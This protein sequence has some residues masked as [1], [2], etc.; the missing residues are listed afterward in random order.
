MIDGFSPPG[1][2]K[3]INDASTYGNGLVGVPPALQPLTVNGLEG[4]FCPESVASTMAALRFATIRSPRMVFA[5]IGRF[6]CLP[7]L[8]L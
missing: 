3:F 7:P 8:K 6:K 1:R 4:S 2:K 5:L